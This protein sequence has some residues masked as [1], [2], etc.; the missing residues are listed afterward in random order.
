MLNLNNPFESVISNKTNEVPLLLLLEPLQDNV[1]NRKLNTLA[2]ETLY[3]T[4][5]IR[6]QT[7]VI[8]D[9]NSIW[10]STDTHDEMSSWFY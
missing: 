9:P 6:I 1:Y 8:T 10:I 7:S 5:Y 3:T 2:F 4:P